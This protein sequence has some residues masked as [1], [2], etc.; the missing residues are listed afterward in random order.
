VSVQ[1]IF[2]AGFA[3]MTEEK[4]IRKAATELEAIVVTQL[5]SAMRKTVPEGSLFEESPSNEIFRSLLDVEL[6]R[7]TAKTSPFG[8]ADAIV[9]EFR[10]V[11]AAAD[12]EAL[13]APAPTEP[14]A[15]R[16]PEHS[17]PS[18]LESAEPTN[19]ES[20]NPLKPYR[21]GAE[22]PTKALD[23]SAFR[24]IG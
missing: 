15:P 22:G 19:P 2:G 6:A 7:E 18:V 3:G 16:V 13:A 1:E 11:T 9:K 4:Q 8:L 5:L 24:R 17:A 10:G 12:A 20:A 23:P 14:A 21:S